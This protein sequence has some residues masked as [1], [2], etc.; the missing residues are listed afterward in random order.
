MQGKNEKYG[1]FSVPEAKLRRILKSKEAQQLIAALQKQDAQTL[2]RAV[3][4]AQRGDAAAAKEAVQA[5]LQDG[6]TAA[7]AGRL[8]HG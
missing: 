8:G 4:A 1:G 6:E 2:S 3:S 5:L 7:L